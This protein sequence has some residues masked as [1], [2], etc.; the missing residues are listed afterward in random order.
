MAEKMLLIQNMTTTKTTREKMKKEF[1]KLFPCIEA[2][3]NND[4]TIP[5]QD[6]EGDWQPSQCEYCYKI[7]FPLFEWI[8]T[9]FQPRHQLLEELKK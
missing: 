3:C 8:T 4:G 6:R 9:N 2:G 7:R 5:E 1:D